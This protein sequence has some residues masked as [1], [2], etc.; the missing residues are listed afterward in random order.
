M[1]GCETD[2]E[3]ADKSQTDRCVCVH[4]QLVRRQ[5]QTNAKNNDRP[6]SNCIHATLCSCFTFE[7]RSSIYVSMAP[8]HAHAPPF[9][10]TRPPFPISLL[11]RRRL[12]PASWR[13][14]EDGPP[15]LGAR[16]MSLERQQ[17]GASGEG[18]Q[19]L[20]AW[21]SMGGPAAG[22]SPAP[23]RLLCVGGQAVGS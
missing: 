23:F 7:S 9:P 22:V 5:G 1:R 8:N 3:E 15:A 19:P 14:G 13:P 17:R 4:G 2:E 12:L 6:D 20:T 16:T 21:M 11:C 18:R 10:R